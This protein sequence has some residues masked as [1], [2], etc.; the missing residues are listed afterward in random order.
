MVGSRDWRI[1][2][3]LGRVRRAR[4]V[5]ARSDSEVYTEMT[6]R[7]A[8]PGRHPRYAGRCPRSSASSA[9][10]PRA[11]RRDP[12]L[13]RSVPEPWLVDR[14]VHT[15]GLDRE[16][17]L[18]HDQRAGRRRPDRPHH[19]AAVRPSSGSS[20][21]TTTSAQDRLATPGS[22]PPP[23]TL[24]TPDSRAATTSRSP[25]HQNKTLPSSQ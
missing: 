19:P 7:V 9:S 18:G 12:S 22:T 5:G 4:T 16:T 6:L 17:V 1:V 8:S 13:A 23:T 11:V 2:W 24:H 3:P 20:A 25:P 14:L 10:A 21:T 15:A